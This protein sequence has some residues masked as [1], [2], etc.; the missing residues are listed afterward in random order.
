MICTYFNQ[1][2]DQKQQ[3]RTQE[4]FVKQTQLAGKLPQ[5]LLIS[6]TKHDNYQL[7]S[8]T[9]HKVHTHVIYA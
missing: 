4:A 6:I 1:L 2:S 5:Y 9:Q 7:Y 8:I 3:T